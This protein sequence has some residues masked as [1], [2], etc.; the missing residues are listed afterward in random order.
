MRFNVMK[1]TVLE[2]LQLLQGIVEKRTTMPILQNILV[3]A[4]EGRVEMIGTDLEVGLRTH[5]DAQVEE[6]GGVT[7]SGKKIFEIVKSLR[8]GEPVVFRQKDGQQMVIT[9]GD[10]EFKVN[11]IPPDD[12]PPVAASTFQKKTIFPHDRFREMINL[13]S[14]AIAQEQRYY[15][16]GAL[17]NVKSNL[18]E[19]VSTDGHRLSYAKTSVDKLKMDK[20]VSVIVAKK[21]LVELVKTE[22]EILE[23]DADEN[24]LFFRVKNRTLISRIIESKFPNYEAVIPKDNPH[25]LF[26]EREALAQAIRRVSLLSAERSRGIKLTI[27]AGEMDLYSS[28]PEI[29]EARDKLKVDY[30]GQKIDVGFNSQY[31][32]DFLTAISS[33]RVLFKLKDENSS[34]LLQPEPEG[35]VKAQYVLMPMKI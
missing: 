33:E 13:I 27:A 10:S 30:K 1:E 17:L 11:C 7:V 24:N 8:P 2:E 18:L 28:N 19:L 26:V 15:L 25:H 6:A 9:S 35:E 21:T 29:G 4:G 14:F 3:Q 32:L 5:F 16:N 34:A 12:Y 31:L 23:F 22:D 20:P